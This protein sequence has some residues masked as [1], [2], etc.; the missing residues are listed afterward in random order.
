M[1]SPGHR[2]ETWDTQSRSVAPGEHQ[3]TVR[4]RWLRIEYLSFYET[5]PFLTAPNA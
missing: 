1:V 3:P 4:V 5:N 2:D